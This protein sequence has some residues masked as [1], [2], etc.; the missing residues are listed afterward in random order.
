MLQQVNTAVVRW[1]GHYC[2]CFGTKRP[3]VRI[4]PPRQQSTRS[5]A[6]CDQVAMVS[7]DELRDYRILFRWCIPAVGP[8]LRFTVVVICRLRLRVPRLGDDRDAKLATL[9]HPVSCRTSRS[10]C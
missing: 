8:S 2:Y 10:G 9:I 7:G 3:W 6:L 5:G 1:S 4:P